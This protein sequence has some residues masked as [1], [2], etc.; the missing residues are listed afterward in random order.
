MSVKL[1]NAASRAAKNLNTLTN[2][3]NDGTFVPKAFQWI[4]DK[5][6][7]LVKLAKTDVIIA[8]VTDTIAN[9]AAYKADA[10]KE[11]FDAVIAC[12]LPNTVGEMNAK[13]LDEV[14]KFIGI[15]AKQLGIDT[16]AITV[17]Q[18]VVIK[19]KRVVA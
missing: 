5:N 6:G 8:N 10:R 11:I 4:H 2:K 7:S 1:I 18:P 16:T 9:F 17:V 3:L 12:G 15:Y 19:K 14:E 13:K